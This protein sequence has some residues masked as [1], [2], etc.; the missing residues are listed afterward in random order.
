MSFLMEI[1][2]T[3]TVYLRFLFLRCLKR[4]L[5]PTGRKKGGMMLI[6]DKIRA[7]SEKPVEFYQYTARVLYE[8][9]EKT[10]PYRPL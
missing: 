4:F 3:L 5:L 8:Y 2:S 10:R 7:Q 1:G 9:A 6:N